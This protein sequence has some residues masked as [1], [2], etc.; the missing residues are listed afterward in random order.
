LPFAGENLKK[1]EGQLH[2]YL[3][4]EAQQK[5]EDFKPNK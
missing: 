3:I 2:P 4:A 5:V 1:L